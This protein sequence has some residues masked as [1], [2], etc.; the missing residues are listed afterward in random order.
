MRPIHETL[1]EQRL[2][3]GFTYPD[4]LKR[5][6][7]Q[8]VTVSLSTVGHWFTGFRKPKMKDLLA[9]CSVLQTSLSAVLGE[10][11]QYAQTDH[12]QLLLS[13]FRHMTHEQQ[14][15]YLMMGTSIVPASKTDSKK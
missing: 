2:R 11:I 6:E 12:E 10:E 8:G 1:K 15:A 3:L 7:L 9:L 13:Q 4:V 14:A 5:L